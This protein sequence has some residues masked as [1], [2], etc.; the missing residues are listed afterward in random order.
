MGDQIRTVSR[1]NLVKGRKFSE[2]L[3]DALTRYTNRSL[4]TA[5]IIAELVSLAKD[6]RADRERAKQLRLSDAEIALYDAIIQNDSA[7]LEMGDEN[8]EDDRPGNW[9]PQSAHLPRWT[10]RSKNRCVPACVHASND[11]LPSTST[12]RTSVNKP[13]SSSSNKRNT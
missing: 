13:Y 9:W 10:G 12:R 6:M 1:K 3:N 2:M 5:E 11:Y 4:T 8:P 7:I